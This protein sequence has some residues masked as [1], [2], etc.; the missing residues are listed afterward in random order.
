MPTT[1]QEQPE[2][3]PGPVDVRALFLGPQ[4][5]NREFFEQAVS[6]LIDEHV[7]WRR[8][9]HPTDAPLFGP[10]QM[11]EPSFTAVQDRAREVLGQ[12]FRQLA[13]ERNAPDDDPLCHALARALCGVNAA[14]LT[15]GL[16]RL[17]RGDD[18]RG[19]V[20][21]MLA[22]ADLAYDQLEHGLAGDR[23]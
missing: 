13:A 7:H 1:P 12:A 17:T 18:P 19:T 3:S 20:A 10:A 2:P 8:D 14:I 21:D 4:A 22:Q 23:G 9:F 6:S 5:E 11:R 16:H 15:C